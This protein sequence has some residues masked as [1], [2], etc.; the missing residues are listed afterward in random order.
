MATAELWAKLEAASDS[1]SLLKKCLD[2]D[3][4]ECLKDKKTK[5]GGTLAECIRSGELQTTF[6]MYMKF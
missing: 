1:K 4:Y 3:T 6:F 2:K 5:F